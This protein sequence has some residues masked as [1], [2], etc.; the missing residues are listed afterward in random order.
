MQNTISNRTEEEQG[1]CW[2]IKTHITE[3]GSKS[4]LARRMDGWVSGWS[5]LGWLKVRKDKRMD[6]D[7][8]ISVMQRILIKYINK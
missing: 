7:Q 1:V 4:W 2:R 3:S 6:G 5:F 8:I